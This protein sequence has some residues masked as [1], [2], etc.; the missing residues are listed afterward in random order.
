MKTTSIPDWLLLAFMLTTLLAPITVLNKILFAVLLIWT[1]VLLIGVSSPR[2]KLVFSAFG[3]VGIFFYGYML[4]LPS[5]NDQDLAVQFFLASFILLLIHF[6]E[7]FN[8]DMDRMAEL[9]GRIMLGITVLYLLLFFNLELP[10]ARDIISWY[11][12]ISQSTTSERDYLGDGLILTLAL[13]TAPFLYVPWCLVLMRIK[14]RFSWRDM[15]WLLFYGLAIGLSGARGIAVVALLFLF[16]IG[17]TKSAI[18]TRMFLVVLVTI[19]LIIL[20]P[21]ILSST[22][23]FSSDEISNATKIGHFQSFLDQLSW[24]NSIFGSGLGS[25]Y[26]SAGKGGLTPHTELTPIDL[27]RY[28]GIPLAIVVFTLMLLPRL[29]FRP[30]QGQRQ[31]YLVAFSLYLL[32]SVTNPV[33]INSFG[34]LV[35]IWYWTKYREFT[36]GGSVRRSS[37]PVVGISSRF[38]L[39]S[40]VEPT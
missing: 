13:S 7:F 28:L 8:I 12:E 37:R 6:I 29:F 26:Y 38:P 36:Y 4:A 30:L 1:F 33:L 11:N 40:K 10:Y 5:S 35:V 39:Q 16:Y 23:L 20:T 19:L 27:A 14:R 25:S 31:R 21:I 24:I 18:V 32:L 3:I 9:C 22:Q 15:M 17:L 34:M 2:P